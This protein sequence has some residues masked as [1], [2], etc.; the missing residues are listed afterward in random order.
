M[1]INQKQELR[2][3]FA[4]M[5]EAAQYAAVSR[6]RLYVWASKRPDLLR[7]NGTSTVIDLRVL[8][9]LLDSL[10]VAKLKAAQ[11]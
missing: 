1:S 5:R 8:D 7:K 11:D 9:E 10:P 6:S 4:R 2:P 3:R